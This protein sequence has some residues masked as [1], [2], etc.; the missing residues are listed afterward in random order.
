MCDEVVVV[1]A[2]GVDAGGL[3][4]GVRAV[5]DPTEGEGPLAGA[6]AGLSAAGRSPLA[7]LVGGDMPGLEP[8][9][10]R[11][12]LEKAEQGGADAVA[13]QEEG[14]ARPLPLALRTRPA[15]AAAESLLQTGRRS[16][17]ELVHELRV[18]VIDEPTWTALDP[19]RATLRDIDEP[20]DLE[21]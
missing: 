20:A 5:H 6:H 21:G 1:L 17:R 18:V 7:L 3:P 14:R 16:L 12:M 2:P 15:A 10:L 4:S 9:V 11:S 8:A 13:L 19:G